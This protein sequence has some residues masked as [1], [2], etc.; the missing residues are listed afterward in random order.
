MNP[1]DK[2][3]RQL[4]GIVIPNFLGTDVIPVLEYLGAAGN[5]EKE[6]QEQPREAHARFYNLVMQPT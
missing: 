1:L 4:P 3:L 6:R 5:G 2:E